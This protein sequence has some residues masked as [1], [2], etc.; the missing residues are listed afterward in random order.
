M[1]F[2]LRPVRTDEMEMVYRWRN[3]PHVRAVMPFSGAIDFEAHRRWWPEAVSDPRRRM[4]ILE[5]GGVPV[6]IV[7]FSDLVPGVS[8]RWGLY[9]AGRLRGAWIAADFAGMRYGFEVLRVATLYCDIIEAHSAALRLR[10]GTGAERVAIRPLV[11]GGP[12]FAE[13]NFTRAQYDSGEWNHPFKQ[14]CDLAMVPDP[15]DL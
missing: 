14:R 3:Q 1:R 5:D 7:V 15:R 4:L 13:W 2:L 12:K 8:A 11:A 9:T 10:E 6:A